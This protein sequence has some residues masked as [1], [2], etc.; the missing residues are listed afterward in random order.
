MWA[1]VN[2]PGGTAFG[3]RIPGIEV[4]GKTGTVQVARRDAVLRPGVDRSRLE[5]HAWFT[6]FAPL[7]DPKIVVV[8][9]V[10]HGGHGSSAAA[11]IARLLLAKYFGVE[12]APRPGEPGFVS[13]SAKTANVPPPPAPQVSQ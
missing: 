12:V 11:P 1:V 13:A 7:E 4:G 5:D 2:E 9:F 3:S 10:E 8:V 6:A